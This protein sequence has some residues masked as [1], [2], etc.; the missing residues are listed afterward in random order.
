MAESRLTFY[1]AR[2]SAAR[3]RYVRRQ[4]RPVAAV[5]LAL[6][7][8][9]LVYRKWGGEQRAKAGDWLVDNGGDVYTVDAEV[10][11]RTY[12]QTGIGTYVKTTPIWAERVDHP[13][14]V[15]TKEGSTQYAV[16]DYLLSNDSDGSDEYAITA[17][18]FED[19]Y[20]VDEEH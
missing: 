13:G 19:L 10:F 12:Q 5:R 18:Q 17:K 16:G 14:T 3:R 2:M 1:A 8:D 4:D 6:D 11:A 7:T 9:G 20:K 15:K